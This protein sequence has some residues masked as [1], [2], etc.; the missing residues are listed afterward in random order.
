[1]N[2]SSWNLKEPIDAPQ[3]NT[4]LRE[5]RDLLKSLPIYIGKGSPESVQI[6]NIGSMYL[7][8][9]GGAN[10]T[11]YVKESSNGKSTGWAAK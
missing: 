8:L 11:L 1:M 5:I 6:A 2:I 10:T 3:I 9:D 4:A 7:R